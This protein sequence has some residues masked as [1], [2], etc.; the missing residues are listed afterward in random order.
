MTN[1]CYSVHTKGHAT[2]ETAVATLITFSA[3][4]GAYARLTAVDDS[5]VAPVLRMEFAASKNHVSAYR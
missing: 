4:G 3:N 2:L 1:D 5:P